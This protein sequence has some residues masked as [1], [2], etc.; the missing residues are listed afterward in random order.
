MKLRTLLV[1]ATMMF[2]IGFGTGIG[3]LA[4]AFYAPVTPTS[5]ITASNEKNEDFEDYIINETITTQ[6]Y[7]VAMVSLPEVTIVGK[8]NKAEQKTIPADDDDPSH[9][10]ERITVEKLPTQK[11]VVPA[12]AIR[13][14]EKIPV[15]TQINC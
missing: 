5:V 15:P 10:T 4:H 7:Y 2:I 6:S 14:L 9:S 11:I 8:T 13:T 3:Q 12:M 1:F